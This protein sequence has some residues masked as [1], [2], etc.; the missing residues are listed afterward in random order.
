MTQEQIARKTYFCRNCS[1][2]QESTHVPAS[3]YSLARYAPDMQSN[4]KRRV[5]GMGLFC[6]LDCVLE[7]GAR[8][9]GGTR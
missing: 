8:L 3:W 4:G 1:E 2:S 9:K 6:S 7:Q 5:V